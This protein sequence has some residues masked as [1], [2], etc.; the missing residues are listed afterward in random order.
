MPRLE[1]PEWLILVAVI[2]FVA[3]YWRAPR[4][5]KPLRFL[6]LSLLVIALCEP[7]LPGKGRGLDLWV[8]V[9]RSLSTK[10]FL[11]PRLEEMEELLASSRSSSDR[12]FF[13]DF[14]RDARR[15]SDSDAELISGLGETTDLET[16]L[17]VALSSAESDRHSR[18]LL[19]SDGYST[20]PLATAGERLQRQGVP[21]DTRLV[22]VRGEADWQV[23]AINVRT[24]VQPRE[25]FQIEI[26]I[27]GYPAL[28]DVVVPFTVSRNGEI[29]AEQSAEIRNGRAV[30]RFFDRLGVGGGV[31]YDVEL[32]AG[33]AFPG[34]DRATAWVEVDGGPSILLVTAYADDPVAAVLLRQGFQLRVV[35]EPRKLSLGD[36][37]GTR[38]IIINNVPASE[39]PAGFLAALDHFVNV[40]GGGLL[41]AGGKFS[42]GSGGYFESP[43]D[44][45]LPVS[46]ELREDHRT[47][48]V[49]MAIVMDRS[50][51]MSAGVSGGK[52]KMDLANE[53]A[54]RSIELLGPRDAVTVFA[55]DS[56]AHTIVPL[57]ALADGAAPI[58]DKVRRVQ[59]MG[60][61]IYVYE[62]LRAAWGELKKA[63]QG[64]RHVI[65]FSDA[66]DSEQPGS[67]PELISEMVSQNTTV[68]VIGLGTDA[69]V[70]AQLLQDI[71]R[72]G[73]GRIFFNEDATA[74]PALFAQ[75]TVAV[76]RST[77]VDEPVGVEPTSGW[78]EVSS[79]LIENLPMVDGYNLS[80]LRD[81]ASAAATARDDYQPPL[82]AFWN[83]GGG[84]VAAISFP[85]GGEY[86]ARVRRWPEFGD[87]TQTLARWLMGDDVP[88][89]IGLQTRVEGQRLEI[90]LLFD[91]SWE[92]RFAED[93]PEILLARGS[94]GEPETLVW[95]RLEPGRFRAARTLESGS[96]Y[97]GAVAIGNVRLPFGPIAAPTG[98]EWSFDEK[99]LQEVRALSRA[100]GGV[101]RTELATVWDD[102][103][104]GGE[105]D[106]RPHVL[107]VFLVVFLFEALMTRVGWQLP[108][109]ELPRRAEM[110]SVDS[111]RAVAA[112]VSMPRER[113]L[114]K[115]VAPEPKT[116]SADERRKRFE[117][118]K[119]GR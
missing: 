35:N 20:V 65:L 38:G 66:A 48:S 11:E 85:L 41:M 80:Y 37:A 86:S 42:F 56:T 114:R 74:L 57:T 110:L 71:A 55:V 51:S 94:S 63:P 40:Q 73:G 101:E 13:V 117:R 112:A 68:S 10:E 39:F 27:E 17:H 7:I 24:R 18:I 6:A 83:R 79:K 50:G 76:A 44:P 95:E 106:L 91:A 88:P 69:D 97:R 5:T 82:V 12:L 116:A 45:L 103:M 47:L 75:E 70:D 109:F 111:P 23:A 30:V 119:R 16:A 108:S 93:P 104:P 62:G 107:A 92:S 49:A 72:R 113:E 61:G 36:L 58:I 99:R 28:Q 67:Y 26:H 59:S 53:G 31:R 81:G 1:S 33:D 22:N 32:R 64:Q 118:A 96:L 102:R 60:G 25:P 43:I 9:D 21:L 105:L 87:F 15:R 8:L 29:Q 2:L 90:D 89:G 77:F 54:A 34:N 3:W 84:R 14:A 100:S 52:T 115:S 98:A 78:L 19:L 4:L 46:M